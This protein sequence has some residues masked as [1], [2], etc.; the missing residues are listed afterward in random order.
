MRKILFIL[1]MS[2]FFAIPVFSQQNLTWSMA[3]IKGN[4]TLSFL[5][6]VEMKDGESFNI[7]IRPVQKCYAY[8]IVQDSEKQMMVFL[9]RSLA[10][11]ETWQ[12]KPITLTLPAGTETFYV[13]M[14]LSEQKDLKR[15][16]DNF[17]KENNSRTSRN[18]NTAVL[19]VRR[20]TS[21]FKENPEKP[22]NMGGAFRGTESVGT[23]FTGAETYV[24]T[25][26]INH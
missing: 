14:S 8:I 11:G 9:D 25:I 26:V 16:I 20:S 3:L 10:A 15:A 2:M 1:T 24:K 7:T 18:L 21:Q 23:E 17:N 12:T 6:P 4:S 22:V 19:E 13:V 5:Q